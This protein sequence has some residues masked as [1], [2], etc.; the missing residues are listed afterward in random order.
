MGVLA[1]SAAFACGDSTAPNQAPT[2]SISSPNSGTT[3]F[4]GDPVTFQGSANDPESGTLTGSALTWQSSLDG[5]LG[6]GPSLTTSNL[7]TGSHTVTLAAMDPAGGS[8]SAQVSIDIVDNQPPVAT[9]T[10]PLDGAQYLAGTEVE[11][12]ATATDPED[13]SLSGGS[14]SWSSDVDGELGTGSPLMI[15]SLSLGS[16]SVTLTAADSR[17]LET[18]STII[19]TMLANG[20]PTVSISQPADAASVEEGQEV[21]FTGSAT[22]T[23]DGALT[24]A[25]LTW[26]S[27]IDGLFGSGESTATTGL[28]A[29]AHVVTLAAQ[30]AQSQIGSATVSI[31]ISPLSGDSFES[32]DN[33]GEAT[34]TSSG[35]IQAHNISPA[36]DEDWITFTLAAPSVVVLETRGGS[37]DDTVLDLF[38]DVLNLVESNDDGGVGGSSRIT[39]VCGTNEL[40]AGTYFG[41][42]TSFGAATSIL[43]YDL[44]YTAVSC[45]EFDDATPGYQIEVRYLGTPPTP[46]R[47]QT[48][49][50]AAARWAELVVGDIADE[51]VLEPFAPSCFNVELDPLVDQ[52]DDLVIF[53]QV[54]P[55]D[56]P[57]GILGSAGPCFIRTGS[58]HPLVG[59]MS[60][61]SDDVTSLENSGAFD[62][63]ILHEMGHVIGF[64]TL[65]GFLGLLQDPTNPDPATIN[66]THFTGAS[67]IA[68]FNAI[69][70]AAYPDAKV[71]A[72]ND[73][74]TYGPGS[75]NGHWRESVFETELM[76]PA[77]D[78]GVTPISEVTVESLGDMGYDV[79]PGSADPY[80]LFWTPSLVAGGQGT[81]LYFGDDILR[82]P[83]LFTDGDGGL[84][85]LGEASDPMDKDD[86]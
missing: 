64:G 47:Q 30:D 1:V 29:G 61:D 34:A 20:V 78:L 63:V 68:A 33:S 11:F 37:G 82:G 26:S 62:V 49:E 69:G 57:G 77:L 36:T 25:S 60:F 12:S 2:A 70:G 66:D 28:S 75:L 15:S 56:G 65:W 52:I 4:S 79:D 35:A 22:D 51:I 8:G 59:L 32:D 73:N 9:I 54:T 16:H 45:A 81:K 46:S 41:R 38:D 19:V 48:F 85:P 23:E 6:T 14:L 3:A 10:S 39:R 86:R 13:G 71:P 74:T 40:P 18:S 58:G 72:E 55:I 7:S 5:T 43:A 50:D 44:A 83:R 24:G 76:S 27:S 80:T 84:R 42:V 21:T 17:G 53:A 31:E 67:A